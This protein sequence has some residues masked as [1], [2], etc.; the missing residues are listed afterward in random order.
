[1]QT[2]ELSF[3]KRP[4][5]FWD[6]LLHPFSHS[7]V[8]PSKKKKMKEN[9]QLVAKIALLALTVLA[10]IAAK[11]YAGNLVGGAIGVA[12]FYGMTALL[13]TLLPTKVSKK[14]DTEA[15]KNLP[16]L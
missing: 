14:I 3:Q 7:F 1:M 15:R 9:I 12:V 11:A 4:L 10:V 6:H 8:N 13:K 5:S 16:S 2:T